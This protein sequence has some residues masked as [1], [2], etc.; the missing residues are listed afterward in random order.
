MNLL[1]PFFKLRAESARAF[2]GRRNSHSGRGEDFL[3]RQPNFFSETAVTPERKVDYASMGTSHLWWWIAHLRVDSLLLDH[4]CLNLVDLP[5]NVVVLLNEVVL[6]DVVVE[7]VK[8]AL[9]ESHVT[10]LVHSSAKANRFP[11]SSWWSSSC[12]SDKYL[13]IVEAQPVRGEGVC[14]ACE[15]APQ[16]RPSTPLIT[17]QASSLAFDPLTIS[18]A[19]ASHWKPY[20]INL[21]ATLVLFPL[22]ITRPRNL[23]HFL[24]HTFGP[25]NELLLP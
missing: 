18:R 25:Q 14:K 11:V 22:T 4:L 16:S 3:S 19:R 1:L 20:N 6:L 5:L 7:S 15:R 10:W 21:I 12:I 17:S 23:H 13:E 2:T 24:S 9:L 8:V